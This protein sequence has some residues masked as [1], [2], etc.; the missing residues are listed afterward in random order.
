MSLSFRRSL[1]GIPFFTLL[2]LL[3]SA[4]GTGDNGSGNGTSNGNGMADMGGPQPGDADGDEW[5]DEEDNCP[6]NANP[7][8]KDRDADGVGDVCDVCPATANDTDAEC[9][10]LDEAEPNNGSDQAQSLTLVE[11]GRFRQVTGVIESPSLGEQSVDFFEFEAEAGDLIEVQAARASPDTT[12]QPLVEV[13]YAGPEPFAPRRAT[14]RFVAQRQIYIPRS[15]TYR[16]MVSDRRGIAGEKPVGSTRESYALSLRRVEPARAREVTLPQEDREFP[17]DD[18]RQIA[19]VEA[20]LVESNFALFSTETLFGTGEQPFGI[21]TIMVIELEDGTVLE[22]DNVGE[23]F[24]DSRLIVEDPAAGP[25]RII[26]DHANFDGLL[27]GRQYSVTLSAEQFETLPEIEP[28]DT[29]ES[30]AELRYPLEPGSEV[31][32][33]GIALPTMNPDTFDTDVYKFDATAGDIVTFTVRGRVSM[34]PVI[35]LFDE[36]T[37]LDNPLFET[38][39]FQLANTAIIR[40]I[41]PTTGEYFLQVDHAVNLVGGMN[42]PPFEGGPL[43]GYDI[44]IDLRPRLNAVDLLTESRTTSSRL[45][46][47]GDLKTHNLLP[48]QP[49]IADVRVVDVGP[50]VVPDLKLYD[51]NDEGNPTE[52]L[53]AGRA[54]V[55]AFLAGNMNGNPYP[56]TMQNADDLRGGANFDYELDVRFEPVTPIAETEPNENPM[57]ATNLGSIPTVVTGS[58]N[59]GMPDWFAFDLTAGQRVS[60][61]ATGPV[62]VPLQLWDDDGNPL[63]NGVGRIE[64]YNVPSSGRYFLQIVAGAQPADY[65]LVLTD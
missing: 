50:G 54:R 42:P 47:D 4:C 56:L 26:L 51:V 14:D 1:S 21:D 15:G 52:L 10:S 63:P 20:E 6:M 3:V 7:E 33:G 8:Q 17:L 53:N 18:P 38:R 58:V 40:G 62:A 37:S 45:E 12:L 41:L 39:G 46:S 44:L 32:S 60:F 16:V 13:T 25:V 27:D 23:G 28:N 59:A 61:F 30:A 29:V 34:E 22:N 9:Q 57:Q 55:A 5:P 2:F 48:S 36:N 11:S 64:D 19:F 35:V 24:T 31:T 49:A 43:Y 65:T